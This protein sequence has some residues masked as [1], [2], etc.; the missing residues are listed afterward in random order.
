MSK[1]IWQLL[2]QT[3]CPG[4]IYNI[5]CIN[6]LKNV[7]F[8]TINSR[9]WTW[10]WLA[11]NL[12]SKTTRTRVN[13]GV[14]WCILE[15]AARCRL[16]VSSPLFAGDRIGQA[17]GKSLR[18]LCLRNELS[19]SASICSSPSSGLMLAQLPVSCQHCAGPGPLCRCFEGICTIYQRVCKLGLD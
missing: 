4:H 18:C 15:D 8:R 12:L 1:M 17:T 6:L 10:S 9:T 14:Y 7:L 16:I 5:Y 2:W 11:L 3:N 13:C 19:C